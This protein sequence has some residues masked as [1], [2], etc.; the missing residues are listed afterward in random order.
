MMKE[1]GY[2]EGEIDAM[3]VSQL[4]QHK[5]PVVSVNNGAPAAKKAVNGMR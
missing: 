5:W 2:S 1:R 3:S 4:Q